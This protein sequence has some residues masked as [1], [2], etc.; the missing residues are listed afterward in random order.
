[1]STL[2]KL[3]ININDGKEFDEALEKAGVELP[4]NY[5]L[6]EAIDQLENICWKALVAL[7][8]EDGADGVLVGII[9]QDIEENYGE[10]E[11]EV[12]VETREFVTRT[13]YFTVDAKNEEEAKA[14][15]YEECENA[16]GEGYDSEDHDGFDEIIVGD[17]EL[18]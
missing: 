4:E 3:N 12:T 2:V 6:G 15:A 11:Y 10:R 18:V 17:A 16:G 9:K 5:D 14:R 8:T 1:M 13:Y 7:N